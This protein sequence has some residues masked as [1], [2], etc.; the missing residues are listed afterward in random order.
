MPTNFWKTNRQPKQLSRK[1]GGLALGLLATSSASLAAEATSIDDLF[2]GPSPAAKQPAKKPPPAPSPAAKPEE[3]PT[4]TPPA[5]SAPPLSAT[6]E[7]PA[8]PPA[9]ASVL[10]QEDR[11]QPPDSKPTVTG[12]F[13]SDLAYTYAGDKHWSLFNNILDLAAQGRTR[14]GIGWKLGGRV[15]Y[16]PVYAQGDHYPSAVRRDQEFEAMIRE[17]YMDFSAGDWEFRLG[18]Q[19]VIWGEMVGLFFADVVSAWDQRQF[20]LP[21]FDLIRIPQWTARAEYFQGDFHAE[22][23]WI[24]YMSY[25]DIGKPGAEYYPFVPP[26]VAGFQNAI[27]SEDKPTSLSDG[28]YG[29]R[30]S[31][32]TGGWDL[33][34]FYYTANDPSAAFERTTTLGPTPTLTY[35]PIHERIHQ[36]GATLGKDLGP[37][38]LKAEAI[39]TGDKLFETTDAADSDGL[40]QQ[41]IFDYVVGLE[42]SF[43]HETRLNVQAFQ[44]YF[45]N[46]DPNIVPDRTESGVSLLLSTQ[47]FHPKLEPEL[48]LIN[49]LNRTDWSAQF[50]LTWKPDGNWRFAGGVDAFNGPAYG[51]FGRFKNTDRVYAEARYT[52]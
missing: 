26:T 22:G 51:L 42:W 40:V 15:S 12:F 16:D 17:A 43:P 30:L 11:A 14:S 3:R 31:Y 13:Q 37:M 23:I 5:S 33:S 28:A 7:A 50:K 46:H 34:G 29:L 21:D 20:I 25:N 10:A 49:S 8:R 32:L 24:P 4:P 2:G 47:V 1:L 9:P 44:R 6:P 27:T 18:R 45:F 38:V 41:N 39:Y 19:H 48:L 35:R 52:F 36:L